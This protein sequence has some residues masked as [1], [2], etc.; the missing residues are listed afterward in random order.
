[1]LAVAGAVAPAHADEVS[2]LKAAVAALQQ[3]LDQLESK[4]KVVEETNDRQSDQIAQTQA[5]AWAA[6]CSNFTW[7]GDFRYR[8]ETIEQEF[9]QGS[10]S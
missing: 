9:V 6:G 3:R 8:N 1:M 5:A 4:A 2:E 7:K 10:Q